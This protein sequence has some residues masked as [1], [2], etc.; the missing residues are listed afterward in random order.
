MIMRWKEKKR[1]ERKRGLL[2][3]VANTQTVQAW[4][5]SAGGR[6]LEGEEEKANQ[7]I[8]QNIIAIGRMCIH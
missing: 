3:A 4:S 7:F 6:N 8:L 2:T 1:E 5:V